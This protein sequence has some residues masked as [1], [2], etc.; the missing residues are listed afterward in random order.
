MLNDISEVLLTDLQTIFTALF[1][2]SIAYLSNI[3]FSL[4]YNIIMLKEYFC[5][6]KLA[7]GVIKL[8]TFLLGI[9]LMILAIDLISVQLI[10][11]IELDEVTH[12]LI[13]VGTILTCIGSVILKY[14]QEA[15]KKCKMILN[16]MSSVIDQDKEN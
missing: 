3:V 13:T 1:I 2:L 12:E 4:Y 16:G 10:Q 15:Y 9:T 14:I 6:S 11:I 8:I 7:H 5:M